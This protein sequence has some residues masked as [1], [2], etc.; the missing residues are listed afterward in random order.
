MMP[1]LHFP[2]T[3][4]FSILGTQMTH[5]FTP[6]FRQTG[7]HEYTRKT[8]STK[9]PTPFQLHYIRPKTWMR[10]GVPTSH[11]HTINLLPL[12][13]QFQKKY[14]TRIAAPKKRRSHARPHNIP[15]LCSVLSAQK[16]RQQENTQRDSVEAPEPDVLVAP[17]AVARE[18]VRVARVRT[19]TPLGYR[20]DGFQDGRSGA[21]ESGI[22]RRCLVVDVRMLVSEKG[23]WAC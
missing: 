8:F 2:K 11:S 12:F 17:L 18:I 10:F 3:L 7:K 16:N 21:G 19:R 4:S 13:R 15:F 5:Q 22:F 1:F 6:L 20:V 9:R 14:R 23:V